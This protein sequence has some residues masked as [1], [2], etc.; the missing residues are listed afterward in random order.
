VISE[1]EALPEAV[2]TYPYEVV[3]VVVPV[4]LLGGRKSTTLP[5]GASGRRKRTYIA[6]STRRS[7][8]TAGSFLNLFVRPPIECFTGRPLK[9]CLVYCSSLR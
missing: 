1:C 4:M 9:T 2:Q 6:M 5:K 8:K 7:T 3:I